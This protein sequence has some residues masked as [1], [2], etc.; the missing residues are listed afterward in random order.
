MSIARQLYQLQEVDLEFESTE[1]TVRQI[2]R[3]LGESEALVGARNNLVAGRQR[4]EELR[5]QQRS[6]EWEI[7]NLVGKLAKVEEELYSG[8]IRNPKEL[9]NL[10]HEVETLKAQRNQLETK[11][12][13]IMEQA[14]QATGSVGVAENE[15]KIVEAEWRQQQQ[16]LSVNLERSK[17]VLADLI[18]KW[19]QLVTGIESSLIDT[20]H[21]VKRQKGMAVV[22]VEQGIC[23]GCRI[24]LPVTEL[25]RSRS[26]T[27]VRC[28]SCGRIL[29]LA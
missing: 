23:G 16:Q 20:Y 17:A 4:L 26:G 2:T 29:Y 11:A 21:A 10:Q 19:S 7:E 15:F 6:G 25:Q 28:G 5:R 1:Q 8:R 22:R 13:E 12:L 18:Q 9:S 14:E 3:Q 27:M 24:L